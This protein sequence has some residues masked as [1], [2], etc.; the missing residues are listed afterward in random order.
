[1]KDAE[2]VIGVSSCES[3]LYSQQE[4][5]RF[6]EKKKKN[7]KSLGPFVSF[8]HLMSWTLVDTFCH[9]IALRL[10]CVCECRE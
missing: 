1:M 9:F 10:W 7:R 8:L 2:V 3:W 6:F 5:Q 4:V